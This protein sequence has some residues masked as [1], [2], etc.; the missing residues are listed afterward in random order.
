MD[1]YL[2]SFPVFGSLYRRVFGSRRVKIQLFQDKQ[3]IDL[4]QG[5]YTDTTHTHTYTHSLRKSRHRECG[6]RR[7]RK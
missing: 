5:G 7:G 1:R 3:E 4:G 2:I 6:R